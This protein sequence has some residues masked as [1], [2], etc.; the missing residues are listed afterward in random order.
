MTEALFYPWID[1]QD[2]AWLKASLLY[3]DSVRT[4]VP[5]SVD[6]PYSTDTG[7]CLQDAQFLV[8]LR[9]GPS[10]GEVEG[11]TDEVLSH[12]GTPEGMQLLNGMTGRRPHDVHID[13]LPSRIGRLAMMHPEKLPYEIRHMLEAL[14][15]PSSRGAD[16]L[17]VDENFANYYMT[18]LA[19]HLAARVGA[20]LVTSLPTADSFAAVARRDAQLQP[21]L[22]ERRGPFRSRRE[23]EA[24]G[25][26]H[27]MPRHLVPG[28]LAN[29]AIE[30]VGIDPTTP[31]DRLLNFRE[32]HRVE[33]TQFRSAVEQLASAIDV[34]LPA[35]ALRRRVADLHENHVSPALSNLKAA[36]QGRRIRWLCDGL[37]KISFLSAAP[38]TMLI[39]AG[40]AVPYALLVG[41]GISLVATGTM[42]NVDK[43]ESLRT[44]P[45]AYLLALEHE[46]T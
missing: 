1:I 7:R 34:D 14:T 21:P 35:E 40:L 33:L 37:L 13:K 46:L 5:E 20:G 45:Y 22:G 6:T 30:R 9:V 44:S 19:T 11:L 23:Y 16:W 15:A 31:V 2:E 3:W 8:P 24:F 32:Q 18:L 29:L 38:T 28:M 36:L 39:A 17:R 27:A 42:Y 4:I 10:M 25:P 41:A 43:S 26:R 12:L